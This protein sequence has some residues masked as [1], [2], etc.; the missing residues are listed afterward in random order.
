[1]QLDICM[2]IFGDIKLPIRYSEKIRGYLGSKYKEIDFLHNHN[3]SNFVYRYPIV[4]Y[5]I[6]SEIP[7]ILGINKA[8]NIVASIGAVEDELILDGVEYDTF[9]KQIIKSRVN[10]G[11]IDYYIEYEFLSPWIALNQ[12]NSMRYLNSNSIEKEELIRKILI[13]NIISMSKG[14]DYTVDKT[15]NCFINLKEKEVMLKGIKQIAF[16]GS[17]K[18]NFNIPD[19]LGIGKASSKGFGTIKSI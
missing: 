15:I 14:L 6:L 18:V 17:F 16:T 1:M 8:A 19:Y 3:E 13:G 9:E 4:Q 2:V 10:Y 12:Q 11:C 5:K 7:I